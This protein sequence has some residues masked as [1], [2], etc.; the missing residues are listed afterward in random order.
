[1]KRDAVYRFCFEDGA[2]VIT[3]AM[4][5][6]LARDLMAR[7]GKFTDKRFVAWADEMTVGDVVDMD[8]FFGGGKNV[9]TC[10]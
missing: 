10:D 9:T 5:C 6:N 7:H 8:G 1:M 4:T 3:A 2:E